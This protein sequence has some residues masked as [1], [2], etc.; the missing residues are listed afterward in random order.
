MEREE[1]KAVAEDKKDQGDFFVHSG[2]LV[3]LFLIVV[4]VTWKIFTN[5]V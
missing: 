2:Q 1:N 4:K 5:N 3:E